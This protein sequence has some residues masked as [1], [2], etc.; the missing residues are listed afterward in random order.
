MGSLIKLPVLLLATYISLGDGRGASPKKG[1]Q[2]HLLENQ[3]DNVLASD[4]R[5]GPI[6]EPVSLLA[7]SMTETEADE[8]ARVLSGD[9]GQRCGNHA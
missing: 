5:N 7:L 2:L 1:V 6:P 9:A 8:R 3:T 4:V